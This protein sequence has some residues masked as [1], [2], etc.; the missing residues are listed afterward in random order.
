MWLFHCCVYIDCFKEW[1][2]SRESSEA[3]IVWVI[4]FVEWRVKLASC[5]VIHPISCNTWFIR[6]VHSN[7]ADLELIM[8]GCIALAQLTE[9]SLVFPEQ[10]HGVWAAS[11]ERRNLPSHIK[12]PSPSTLPSSRFSVGCK[13]LVEG[14]HAA[15]PFG[16]ELAWGINKLTCLYIPA[17][18]RMAESALD[19]IYEPSYTYVIGYCTR[20]HFR[21]LSNDYSFLQYT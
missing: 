21:F 19:M 1:G 6:L 20:T 2:S 17:T 9:L 10:I 5:D 14:L 3:V 7:S 18:P 4:N 12:S 13:I 11:W 16:R 8:I 15:F